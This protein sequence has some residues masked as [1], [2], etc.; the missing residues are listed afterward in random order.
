MYF[1]KKITRKEYYINTE[2]IRIILEAMEAEKH[3]GVKVTN[4]DKF[5]PRLIEHWE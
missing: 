5:K 1:D 2:T 4:N 3:L